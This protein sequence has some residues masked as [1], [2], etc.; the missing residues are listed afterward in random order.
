MSSMSNAKRPPQHGQ[1]TEEQALQQAIAHHSA[2]ELESAARLEEESRKPEET[3]ELLALFASGRFKSAETLATAFTRRFPLQGFGWKALGTILHKTG[4]NTEALASLKQAV[5]LSPDDAEAHNTLGAT[6]HELTELDA[7]VAIYC[8]ALE[9]KAA[10]PE[11]HNNLGNVLRDLGRLDDAAVSIRRAIEMKPDFAIA[12]SNFSNTLRD[13]GQ[14]HIAVASCLRA[15]RLE[16]EL[17][18][19]RLALVILTLRIAPTTVS[20]SVAIPTEFD[21]ALRSLREWANTLGDPP[22]R[23]H[24]ALCSQSPFYLAYRAGNH[25]ESLSRFGDLIAEFA[26]KPPAFPVGPTSRR[27]RLAIVSSHFRRHS[28][29]DINLR[30]LLVNL[31]RQEFEVMLYHIGHEEDGETTFAKSLADVWRDAQSNSGFGEWLKVISTDQPDV[32]LYPEIG[33]DPLTLR[34]ASCRLA[35]LQVA[36]WGHP[37]T[38]GLPTVDL[39]F[40]GEML[41]PSAADDHYRERLVRLPGTGC[42]T[43][44]IEVVPEALPGLESEL[45]LRRGPRFVMAQMPFKLDPS[46]DGLYPRIAAAVGDSTFVLLRAPIFPWATDIVFSRLNQAF[47]DRG[48]LPEQHLMVVPWLSREKFYAL[49]DLC[50]VYLDCPSFSGYTTAWQA[51]HRGLP[52]VTLEGKFMRQRLAAGLLRKMGLGDTIASSPDDYVAIATRLAEEYRDP[53][54]RSARRQSIKSAAPRMDNDVSVVRAFEKSLIDTLA[55]KRPS[56]SSGDSRR[57]VCE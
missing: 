17:A 20:E 27:I 12:Y 38:T 31:D 32:I 28:V 14:M 48:L 15:V 53:D 34:L 6:L 54:L 23:I 2:G 43:A 56:F 39:Y 42:C 50:D 3:K 35:P 9:I 45:N 19:A 25:V 13:L 40:S 7:A 41:E 52:I 21:R 57:N 18:E 24:E 1:P 16:P 33:M 37:I 26:E 36:G 5:T 8:R 11:A 30:G 47:R 55:E 44:P 4:R 22:A 49:L 51:V 46:D 29:W 10:Y